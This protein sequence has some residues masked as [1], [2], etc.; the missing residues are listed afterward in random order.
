VI[1]QNTIEVLS[2][3]SERGTSHLLLAIDTAGIE[4]VLVDVTDEEHRRI[5]LGS[6]RETD[7]RQLEKTP[8]EA[9]QQ[10]KAAIRARHH[11]ARF[12]Y[13]RSQLTV[14]IPGSVADRITSLRE[15][16][17]IVQTIFPGHAIAKYTTGAQDSPKL[18]RF[19]A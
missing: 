5:C 6:L 19:I 15:L 18:R 1:A 14:V 7:L 2:V 17:D 13:E 4:T 9:C 3:P 12:W 11:T 8:T 10:L 16:A